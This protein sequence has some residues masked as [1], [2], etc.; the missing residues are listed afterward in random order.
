H[1]GRQVGRR[2]VAL[3]ER[4]GRARAED[5]TEIAFDGRAAPG[6]LIAGRIEAHDGR[7]ARL[8]EWEIRP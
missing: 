1:L 4:E 7:R 2:A 5:Y 6:A 8:D 3:V